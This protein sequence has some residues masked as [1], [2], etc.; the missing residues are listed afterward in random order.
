[1]TLIAVQRKPG[2]AGW[3]GW[4]RGEGS[5]PPCS[6]GG[7]AQRHWHVEVCEPQPRVGQL[8]QV[9]GGGCGVAVGAQV[10][11]AQ[12]ISKDQHDVRWV[13]RGQTCSQGQSEGPQHDHGMRHTQACHQRP[14]G[15]KANRLQQALREA[16]DQAVP[17]TPPRFSLPRLEAQTPL[18]PSQTKDNPFPKPRPPT[19]SWD[20]TPWR[21]LDQD[22]YRFSQRPEPLLLGVRPRLAVRARS[23]MT[24]TRGS[25]AA[26]E[27]RTE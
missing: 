1:M 3:S 10:P 22:T 19:L 16:P 18:I 26:G 2:G 7:C 4:A 11:V 20:L 12:V 17:P 6:P 21:L 14:L 23:H 9:G 24:L 5:L 15:K 25:G 8:V 13:G 27:N